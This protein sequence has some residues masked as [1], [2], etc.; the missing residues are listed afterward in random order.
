MTTI[1][2]RQDTDSV[3]HLDFNHRPRCEAH[4]ILRVGKFAVPL[5]FC[6]RTARW[7]GRMPCCGTISYSCDKHRLDKLDDICGRCNRTFR[8]GVIKWVRL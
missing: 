2:P 6:R 3:E 7:A 5:A 4:L 8:R 1:A